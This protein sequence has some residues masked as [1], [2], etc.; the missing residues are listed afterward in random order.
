M[1][2]TL[3]HITNPHHHNIHR[4]SPS[5]ILVPGPFVMAAAMANTSQDLGDILYE[6]VVSCTNIN[7]VNPGDQI[8]TVT[9]V[10]NARQLQENPT[11]EEV[12]LKHLA[13][14]NTE[15]DHLLHGGIPKKLLNRELQKPS[16]YEAVCLEDC[17]LLFL[18]ITCQMV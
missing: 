9:Y 16:E 14:K 7:K 5:D 13:I 12:T 3:L 17:P 2:A 8:N 6:D 15:M 4:Y 11:L 10:M 1:L 18:R